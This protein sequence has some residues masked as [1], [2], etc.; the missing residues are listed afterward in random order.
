MLSK[1]SAEAEYRVMNNVTCEIIWIL[2]VL[3]ELNIDT[4][5]PVPLHCNNS[6]A[7]QISTN[8]VFHEKNKHF[9]IKL[10]YGLGLIL[11]R[12]PCA[13]KGV[14]RMQVKMMMWNQGSYDASKALVK[15]L[16]GKIGLKGNIKNDNPNPDERTKVDS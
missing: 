12:A 16:D 14:L 8:P 1:S 9:E 2:K 11:Y 5:L 15:V 7:M 10:R 4:S 6:S 13:I 3:A